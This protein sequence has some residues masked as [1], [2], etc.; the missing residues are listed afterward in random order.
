MSSGER[1]KNITALCGM[2]AAGCFVPPLFVFPLKRM[3]TSIMHGAP[4]GSIGAVN[5]RG[6]GYLDSALCTVASLAGYIDSALCTVASL[7][8]RVTYTRLS[9]L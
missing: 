4:P 1:D 5:D 6:S 8:G 7:A 3:V 2:S 9:V